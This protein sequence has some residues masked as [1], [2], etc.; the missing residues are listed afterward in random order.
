MQASGVNGRGLAGGVGQGRQKAGGMFMPIIKSLSEAS[1][2]YASGSISIFIVLC[3]SGLQT[4]RGYCPLCGRS[5]LAEQ[6]G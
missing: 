6:S 3:G 1:G 5:G 4:S 2:S